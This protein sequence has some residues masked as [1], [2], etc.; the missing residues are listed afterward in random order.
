[1]ADVASRGNRAEEVRTERRRKPGATTVMGLKLHVPESDKDAQYVHRWV[2]DVGQ[3]VQAMTADDWDP[4]PM[5][6]ASTEAR[7][8]GTDSGKPINAV[9]MRKRK[10]WYDAD[11]KDKRQN[12][13]ET[14]KAIQRGTV[15]ANAGEADLKGVDYTP[16]NGNSISRG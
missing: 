7:Y 6:E 8:V 12:L 16:G 14:D 9:L 1:M 3:R 4:A 15:H 11:Q 5:G 13:A 10:D 2:N